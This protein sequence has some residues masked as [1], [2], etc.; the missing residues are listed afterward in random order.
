MQLQLDRA[1]G[2]GTWPCPSGA[3][4]GMPLAAPR[5][6]PKPQAL[7]PCAIFNKLLGSPVAQHKPARRI[8]GSPA[9]WNQLPHL[10]REAQL[11][12]DPGNRRPWEAFQHLCLLLREASDHPS[13]GSSPAGAVSQQTCKTHFH[14]KRHI[15]GTYY[16][17]GPEV[18]GVTRL[19]GVRLA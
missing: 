2:G 16:V 5:P 8:L 6:G 4:E 13:A 10:H 9:A 1:G 15:Q 11:H 3:K 17:P 18:T 19:G 7:K 12:M 14:P